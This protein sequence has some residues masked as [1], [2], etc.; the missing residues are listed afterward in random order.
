MSSHDI[1]LSITQAILVTFASELF[2]STENHLKKNFAKNF[3]DDVVDDVTASNRLMC[4]LND[5]I[6]TTIFNAV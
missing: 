1:L 2:Y 5:D 6:S 4:S 3:F